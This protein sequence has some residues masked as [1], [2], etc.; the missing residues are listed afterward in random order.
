MNCLG[1]IAVGNGCEVFMVT[2]GAGSQP[3]ISAIV[4]RQ[5]ESIGSIRQGGFV[6]VEGM[7]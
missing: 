3:S 4:P 5:D 2:I 1:A 6:A 7:G